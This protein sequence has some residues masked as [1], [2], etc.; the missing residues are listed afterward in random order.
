MGWFEFFTKFGL[1]RQVNRTTASTCLV[2]ILSPLLGYSA[3]FIDH[4]IE[5][6][7]VEVDK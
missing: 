5:W 3:S 4:K 6:E 7:T 1:L 2:K